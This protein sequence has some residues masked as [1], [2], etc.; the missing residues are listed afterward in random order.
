[1]AILNRGIE[2]TGFLAQKGWD[3]AHQE[4]FAADFS[5]RRYARLTGDANKR[6]ILM[7]ADPDQKTDRFVYLANYLRGLNLLAPEIYAADPHRGLVLMQDFGTRNFGQLLDEGADPVTLYHRMVDVLVKLH[8]R[9]NPSSLADVDLPVFNSALF[10]HQAELYLDFYAPL[11]RDRDVTDSE[12]EDF[13]LA[14]SAVLRPLESL[15][16]SLLLRDYMPD[17]VM[18]VDGETGLLDFQDAGIGPIAYDLASMCETVRRD[19]GD[20]RLDEMIALYHATA[21]PDIS[22]SDLRRACI[23]L[24]AQRHTRILG[25]IV[26]LAQQTG[27]RDKMDLLPRIQKHLKN[28]SHDDALKP[29]RPW[30]EGL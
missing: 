11:M 6:A 2:I 26:K 19:G 16:Q 20:Q 27:R 10:A 4:P 7:D 5:P 24:S 14:W 12:R 3:K 17:N 9:C 22:L 29:V 21:K 30:M 23:I 13:H 1:M 25:I 8:A 18:D 15:P 28:L